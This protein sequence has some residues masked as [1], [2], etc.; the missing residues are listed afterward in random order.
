[1]ARAIIGT[2][3]SHRSRERCLAKSAALA[4]FVLT[5]GFMLWIGVLSD[6]SGNLRMP[7]LGSIFYVA[8]VIGVAAFLAYTDRNE[9]STGKNSNH[10]PGYKGRR[11]ATAK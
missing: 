1:M 10:K 6:S 5:V 2:Q 11:N 9:D 3:L 4:A 8:A 7:G